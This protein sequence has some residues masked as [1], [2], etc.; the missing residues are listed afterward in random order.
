MD[1]LS[2]GE[3]SSFSREAQLIVASY[4]LHNYGGSDES[5]EMVTDGAFDGLFHNIG[6]EYDSQVLEKDAQANKLLL[7]LS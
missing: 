5:T 3:Y 7:A 2:S 4:N 1:D 6:F